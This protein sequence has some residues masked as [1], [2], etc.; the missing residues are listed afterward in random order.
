MQPHFFHYAKLPNVQVLLPQVIGLLVKIIR[1]FFPH[2]KKKKQKKS[3]IFFFF[4]FLL[5][6]NISRTFSTAQIEN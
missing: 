4:L 6:M 5:L 1:W 2:L 3:E